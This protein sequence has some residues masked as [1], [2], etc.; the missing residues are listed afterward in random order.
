MHMY[1]FVHWNVSIYTN[2]CINICT[3]TAY[4]Y[5]CIC[6]YLRIE[7]YLHT[8]I[9]ACADDSTRLAFIYAHMYTCT[10]IWIYVH[11]YV[12]DL[13]VY[14]CTLKAS[15]LPP[16]RWSLPRPRVQRIH[17]HSCMH[18]HMYVYVHMYKK[19][20]T[21]TYTCIMK[22]YL[23]LPRAN[24]AQRFAFCGF[25]FRPGYL[26][27]PLELFCICTLRLCYACTCVYMYVCIYEYMYMYICV[28]IRSAHSE[29]SDAE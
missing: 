4:T 7:I 17:V 28:Y 20:F 2:T 6:M 5:M 16:T 21:R 12:H 10:Y 22:H 24:H 29:K 23:C 26:H 15:S 13:Y 8:Q 18:M 3:N 1:V 11:T 14:I 25:H 19:I 9:H 27:L